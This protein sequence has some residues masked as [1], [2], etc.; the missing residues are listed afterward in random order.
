[1]K[2]SIQLQSIEEDKHENDSDGSYS[3]GSQGVPVV[4]DIPLPDTRGST[5][6]S[7][8]TNNEDKEISF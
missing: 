1:M 5:S 4:N 6:M 8:A 3:K 2:R 7:F